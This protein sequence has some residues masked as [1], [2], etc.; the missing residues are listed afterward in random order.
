MYNRGI[1]LSRA[2]LYTLKHT[3][4]YVECIQSETSG[5]YLRMLLT[6]LVLSCGLKLKGIPLKSSIFW[7]ITL[8]SPLKRS[9]RFGG[10]YCLHLQGRISRAGYRYEIRWQTKESA[11]RKFRII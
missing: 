4:P 1:F 10:T 8:Y 9:R 11:G 3:S 7:E 2:F 5:V 6:I